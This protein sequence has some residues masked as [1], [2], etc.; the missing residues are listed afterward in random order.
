L[1]RA[2]VSRNSSSSGHG[3]SARSPEASDCVVRRGPGQFSAIRVSEVVGVVSVSG[4]GLGAL[5][6]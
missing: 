1:R 3:V 5:P 2:S 4:A 6:S